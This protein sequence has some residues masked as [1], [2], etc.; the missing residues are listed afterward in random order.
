M[1]ITDDEPIEIVFNLQAIPQAY[2]PSLHDSPQYNFRVSSVSEGGRW[3]E[4]AVGKIMVTE[5][6]Q[7]ERKLFPIRTDLKPYNV[8]A[9]YTGL[10]AAGVTFGPSF[11]SLSAISTS[12]EKLEAVAEIELSTTNQVMPYQSHYVIHPA[13]LDG[14]LQLS[15]VAALARSPLSPK[16]FLPVSID[17]MTIWNSASNLCEKK[18]SILAK[19][20]TYGL[21][22]IKGSAE[23]FDDNGSVL[24]QGRMTFLSLENKLKH[25]EVTALRQPYTQLVWKP[26]IDMLGLEHHQDSEGDNTTIA[27]PPGFEESSLIDYMDLVVHKGKPIDIL[28]IGYKDAAVIAQ[29]LGGNTTSPLYKS[30]KVATPDTIN[31][32]SVHQ[33]LS[34]FLNI[35]FCVFDLHSLNSSKYDLVMLSDVC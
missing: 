22:S 29:S 33:T 6:S 4:H 5:S 32:E 28:Q 11:Q 27:I 35:E 17:K 20:D 30:Y 15:A 12:S 16:A 10:A 7:F 18:L 21:R 14:C 19:G 13:T 31:L 24:I 2:K 9:W 3:L 1:I 34:S 25:Q 26:D 8:K 23:V